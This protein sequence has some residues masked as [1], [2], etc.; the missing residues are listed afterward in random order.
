MLDVA[1][2]CSQDSLKRIIRSY[3]SMILLFRLLKTGIL[4]RVAG[5]TAKQ[6][7]ARILNCLS[8]MNCIFST[9]ATPRMKLSSRAWGSSRRFLRLHR[10]RS[11]VQLL[12]RKQLRM[13]RSKSLDSR[14]QWQIT[15]KWLRGL[16]LLQ[17]IH[18]TSTRMWDRIQLIFTLLVS[19][20]IIARRD[21]LPCNDTC[22][23]GWSNSWREI[24]NKVWFSYRI[25][26]RRRSLRLT[27][28]RWQQA[29]INRRNS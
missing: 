2:Q 19:N 5:K 25:E 29:T 15:E 26:S 10:L 20:N 6:L 28:K 1:L 13:I 16:E 18:L 14:L 23:K 9:K 11:Q 17:R 24:S 8:R 27:C 3:R 12:K 21:S 7:R 4:T 22:I